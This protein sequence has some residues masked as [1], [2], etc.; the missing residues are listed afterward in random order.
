MEKSSAV[1]RFRDI[2]MISPAEGRW[3]WVMFFWKALALAESSQHYSLLLLAQDRPPIC[4]DGNTRAY[5]AR[6][7]APPLF[8]L[9]PF[10]AFA[11][12]ASISDNG[13]DPFN[14]QFKILI[15][16]TYHASAPSNMGAENS[17]AAFEQH[18][19]FEGDLISLSSAS[20]QQTR[21]GLLEALKV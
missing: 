2:S 20:Q 4:L 3:N 18:S 8:I 17:V 21:R 9:I 6:H 5:L 16:D 13:D 14:N 19:Q 11:L 10:S 1:G 15:R 7:R 12:S